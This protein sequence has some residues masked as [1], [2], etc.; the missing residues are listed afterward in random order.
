MDS[1]KNKICWII[2]ILI[3]IKNF[4]KNLFKRKPK[5]PDINNYDDFLREMSN[6]IKTERLIGE[7]FYLN[8]E[9]LDEFGN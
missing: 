1:L 3:K 8:F 9:L 5:Q 7:K 4:I 2:R 6:D